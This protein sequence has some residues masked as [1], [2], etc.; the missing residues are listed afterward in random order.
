[1]K[2]TFTTIGII[3][4]IL[5]AVCAI[6]G[7][8]YYFFATKEKRIGERFIKTEDEAVVIEEE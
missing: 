8:V 3:L 4:S 7:A 1:M 6:L 5:A 2:K